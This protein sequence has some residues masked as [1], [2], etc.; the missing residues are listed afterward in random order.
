[1][2]RYPFTALSLA[3]VC[4]MALICP[5]AFAETAGT[6]SASTSQPVV[7][8][9]QPAASAQI[10]PVKIQKAL[11]QAGY[12]KGAIDGVIGKRTKA[13]IR[14]FQKDNGLSVDGRVGPKT[15][16]KLE[17]HLPA[18][19]AS[20]GAEIAAP[21]TDIAADITAAEAVSETPGE[22]KQKLVQ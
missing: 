7:T 9:S 16:A 5:A 3:F 22:L 20:M 8:A 21:A 4:A 17:T 13:S 10:E 19:D 12:Y 18:D 11:V 2:K 1:M 15:W 6:P 14:S